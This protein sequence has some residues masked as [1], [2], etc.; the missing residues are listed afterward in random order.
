[1]Y[2]SLNSG[3]VACHNFNPPP[4]VLKA[5]HLV[6]CSCCIC[7]C[8]V[9]VGE[10]G[11]LSASVLYIHVFYECTSE[12]AAEGGPGGQLP[13]NI[14]VG[15]ALPPKEIGAIMC[16]SALHALDAF[17]NTLLLSQITAMYKYIAPPHLL[18]DK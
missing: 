9:W 10:V 11:L 7:V 18:R 14:P 8:L 1:M 17:R 12:V 4:P 13:L 2:V 3:C 5:G 16:V 6:S 15:G